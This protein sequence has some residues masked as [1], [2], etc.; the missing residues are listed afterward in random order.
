MN[1]LFIFP[2]SKQY[3]IAFSGKEKIVFFPG[4][5]ALP[6]PPR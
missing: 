3:S 5:N 2:A 6:A 4:K 1:A